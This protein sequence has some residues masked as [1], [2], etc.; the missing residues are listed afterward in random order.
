METVRNL[1]PLGA[2]FSRASTKAQTC[3]V[4][5]SPQVPAGLTQVSEPNSSSPHL[6][7]TSFP[8]IPKIPAQNHLVSRLWV[9]NSRTK[10]KK[11]KR[12]VQHS[13]LHSTQTT[14]NNTSLAV[15][16]TSDSPSYTQGTDQIALNCSSTWRATGIRAH[17]CNPGSLYSLSG[18]CPTSTLC[19][20]SLY[21]PQDRHGCVGEPGEGIQPLLALF[22]L[23]HLAST[24]PTRVRRHLSIHPGLTMK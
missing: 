11:K 7:P 18:P 19:F 22:F 20:V 13:S 12:L 8:R 15:I 3:P 16:Q 9:E 5:L 14:C 24:T 2:I 23:L 10:K 21:L 17:T 1:P 4:A 6:G